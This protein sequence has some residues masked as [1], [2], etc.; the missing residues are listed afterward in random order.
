MKLLLVIALI[1]IVLSFASAQTILGVIQ[2]NTNLSYLAGNLT[3]APGLATILSSAGN[4]T[5]FAPNNAAFTNLANTT[6][7]YPSINTTLYYHVAIGAI[8]STNLP[9]T[10][11]VST[12]A[13]YSLTINNYTAAGSPFNP[14]VTVNGAVFQPSAALNATNGNVDIIQTVLFPP[15]GNA[16][17]TIQRLSGYN[18]A[19]NFF[20]NASANVLASINSATSTLFVPNNAAFTAFNNTLISSY[21]TSLNQLNTTVI[22]AIVLNHLLNYS[23]PVFYASLPASSSINAASAYQSSA[24][25]ITTS[26]SSVTVTSQ[27][28]RNPGSVINFDLVTS[29]GAI[30]T[31]ST[32]LLPGG[33]FNIPTPAPTTAPTPGPTTSTGT[34]G[35][36]GTTS[37]AS[38]VQIPVLVFALIALLLSFF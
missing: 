28:N 25:N 2:G 21:N 32:V 13:G 6:G 23:F 7:L 24:L 38:I 11:S 22:N 30:F 31:T 12:L 15:L 17:Q 26:G 35:T 8:S 27:G 3:N 14:V 4:Y 20:S 18:F 36:T 34:T 5:V 33:I 16:M 10:S 19:Y 1:C 29:S 37:G 9:T